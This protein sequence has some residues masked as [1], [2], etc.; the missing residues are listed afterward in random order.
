M[1][2]FEGALPLL[3]H[4]GP[5]TYSDADVQEL[6]EGYEGYFRRGERYAV[7]SF[8][9]SLT[10]SVPAR[11]RKQLI[12][13]LQTPRVRELAG[14]FCVGGATV[15]ASALARGAMTALNWFW[16]PPFPSLSVATSEEGIDWCL[17]QLAAAG[18]PLPRGREETRRLALAHVQADGGGK[19]APKTLVGS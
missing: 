11:Q 15:V 16:K 10:G 7:L 19:G 1:S 5:R 13:W 17:D 2:F 12:D 6:I 3:V 8:S 14:R 18:V 9:T 4:V